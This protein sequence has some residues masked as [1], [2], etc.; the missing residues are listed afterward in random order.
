MNRIRADRSIASADAI[1]LAC[2]A[3]AQVDLFLA[4]DRRLAGKTIPGLQFIAN[5]SFDYL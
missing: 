3:Q 4:N 5:L 1:Q 2:A